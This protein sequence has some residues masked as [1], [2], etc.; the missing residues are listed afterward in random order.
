MLPALTD[1]TI[2]G[3]H[4]LKNINGNREPCQLAIACKRQ[5][6]N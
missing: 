4:F 5:S 1:T 2:Y 3:V 6:M